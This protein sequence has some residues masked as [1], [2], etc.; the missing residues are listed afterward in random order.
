M[1]APSSSGLL[2]SFHGKEQKTPRVLSPAEKGR[3]EGEW[4]AESNQWWEKWRSTAGWLASPNSPGNPI[5]GQRTSIRM[6]SFVF[7]RHKI[8]GG[9]RLV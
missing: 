3:R 6:F 9:I 8:I 5:V 2:L 4:A 1:G 7:L